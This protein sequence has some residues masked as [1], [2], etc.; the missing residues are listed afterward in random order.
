MT[1]ISTTGYK[2]DSRDRHEPSLIIPSNQI[3]MNNVKH[4]VYGVDNYGHQQMMY[5]GH[6]YTFPGQYV[7]E[8][9]M[10]QFG[11]T[12]PSNSPFRNT[13]E[14]F[15]KKW[16]KP[17]KLST[18]DDRTDPTV[19]AEGNIS[20]SFRRDM[21]EATTRGIQAK[22]KQYDPSLKIDGVWGPLTESAY[23]KYW[24]LHIDNKRVAGERDRFRQGYTPEQNTMP[25]DVPQAAVAQYYADRARNNG[26]SVANYM[27]YERNWNF[28]KDA[29]NVP[30]TENLRDQAAQIAQSNN[31]APEGSPA[32]DFYNKEN[33]VTGK[34]LS[35]YSEDELV[36]FIQNNGSVINTDQTLSPGSDE[37]MSYRKNI[38][39]EEDHSMWDYA[40]HYYD[41]LSDPSKASRMSSK[42]QYNPFGDLMLNVP[43]VPWGFYDQQ[44][45]PN[46]SSADLAGSAL[47]VFNPLTYVNAAG[48]LAED[49]VQPESYFDLAN[50]TGAAGKSFLGAVS[51]DDIPISGQ[52]KESAL[53]GLGTLGDM[54]TVAPIAPQV[55]PFI[56]GFTKGSIPAALQRFSSYA[57]TPTSSLTQFE[58]SSLNSLKKSFNILTQN[59]IGSGPN[60]SKSTMKMITSD[61]KLL[62]DFQAAVKDLHPN[63]VRDLIG[64][65]NFDEFSHYF[66]T[67]TKGMGL[68]E[69]SR[70]EKIGL[71]LQSKGLM[72]IKKP[73][74]VDM[75]NPAF[76][77][78]YNLIKPS[79]FTENF[80]LE[81]MATTLVPQMHATDKNVVSKLRDAFNKLDSA[82]PGE[83]FVGSSNMSVDSYAITNNRL[84]SS[85]KDG[86][87]KIHDIKM[88][89]LNNQGTATATKNPSFFKA[90]LKQVNEEI[91]NLSKKINETL[92]KAFFDPG[93]S[94]IVA[95]YVV[96][97]KVAPAKLIRVQVKVK[98]PSGIE[99]EIK[100]V[101]PDLSD[102]K[103]NETLIKQLPKDYNPRYTGSSPDKFSKGGQSHR[104]VN[105]YNDFIN[106][107]HS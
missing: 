35:K 8:V 100:Y 10:A 62:M 32:I 11:M 107:W 18:P 22:L 36:S 38:D 68:E 70:L 15:R 98:T 48:R 1:K 12:V 30:T 85:I 72:S 40:Q 86:S 93:S 90:A 54:L 73:S 61:P 51:G 52:Q 5:P 45:N 47:S 88:A 97:E 84:V 37:R 94:R 19:E 28:N 41:I 69:L 46:T 91:D 78:G 63:V 77:A 99:R 53:R 82:E 89:P 79:A 42:Q 57:V 65:K 27:D 95:P 24:N 92:P 6:D 2:S 74:A 9:P 104:Y 105:S 44:E 67:S 87:V 7:Y 96:V 81:K 59:K 49:A 60:V 75:D 31:I 50:L 76:R 29:Q 83:L 71:G 64:N 13:T 14:E 26:S 23:R 56:K 102:L 4:P 58:K 34:P 106:I 16:E 55:K 101:K 33:P 20:G 80:E 103:A 3:T 17:T 39:R 25:I 66:P 21:G 43:D